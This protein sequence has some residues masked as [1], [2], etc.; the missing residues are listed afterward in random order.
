[1]DTRETLLKKKI[2]RIQPAVCALLLRLI[3]RVSPG[4]LRSKAQAMIVVLGEKNF[5]GSDTDPDST[6]VQQRDAR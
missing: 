2:R 4:Y 1:M 6:S 3:Y 5:T